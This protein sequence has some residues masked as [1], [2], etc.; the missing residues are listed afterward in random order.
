MNINIDA[1]KNLGLTESTP[2]KSSEELGQGEFLKLLTTQMNH[3]DPLKPLDSADF[4]GQIAQFGTVS[5]IQDLQESFSSF[6]SSISSDQALQ[7]AQLVGRQVLIEG[8]EG[9]LAAGGQIAGEVTVPADASGVSVEIFNLNGELLRTIEIGPQK[10]GQPP[11]SWDG[12]LED[13]THAEP[14]SYF[15]RGSAQIAGENQAL[16]TQVRAEVESVSLG[17]DRDGLR[18]NLAGLG[19]VKFN[20]VQRIL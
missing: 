13:G 20:N 2:E 19:S 5:G 17:R 4:L 18:L 9:V 8:N 15:V 1:I 12:I 10:A 6:A 11:F 3:Q 7:A 16:V 14:G